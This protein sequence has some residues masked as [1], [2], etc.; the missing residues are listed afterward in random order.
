ME[1]DLYLKMLQDYKDMNC[2]ANHDDTEMEELLKDSKVQRYLYLKEL[3]ENAYRYRDKSRIIG[4]LIDN[5]GYGAIKETNNI[6]YYFLEGKV[7]DI[8]RF[9]HEELEK[10]EEQQEAIIYLDLENNERIRIV[11]KE[12]QDVFEDNNYVVYGNMDIRD[13]LDRYYNTR[14]PFFQ[15]CLE[16]GQATAIKKILTREYRRKYE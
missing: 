10:M 5:Y 3:R 8:K 1:K 13:A 14:K 12:K 9:A 11:K 6:W 16:L 4:S 2:I 15:D 7:K